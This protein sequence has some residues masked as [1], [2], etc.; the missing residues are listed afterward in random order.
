MKIITKILR[1]IKCKTI[2]SEQFLNNLRNK[3]VRIGQGTIVFTPNDIQIDISRPEL[4]E[5]GDNVLLHRGTIIMTHDYASRC[6]VNKYN[7]FIP[8]HGKVKIGNNVWLGQHVTILKG[9]T[10]GDN[11]IIGAGSIVSK[12]IPSNSV[13]VGSPAKVICTFEEYYQKRQKQYIN[14]CI[15]YAE[16][17]LDSGRTPTIE[18]FYDDYPCFVDAS[19]MNEYN[20]PYE[21]VFTKPDQLEVWKKQHKKIFNGFDDFMNE[22]YRRRKEKEHE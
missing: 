6:F 21:R 1:R 19:N 10:I 17:I 3:G 18:D 5:I 12:S 15:E 16:A 11:V 14:E 9:V 7:D 22:V 8:S 4:L 20:Y 13:A 2:T